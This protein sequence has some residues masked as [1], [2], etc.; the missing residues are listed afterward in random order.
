VARLHSYRESKWPYLLSEGYD[1]TSVETWDYNCIAFVAGVQNQW[2]W[3]DTNG[4]G[5]WP[6]SERKETISCFIKAF[7][8][9]GFEVCDDGLEKGYE[10]IAIFALNGVP[11]H[12]AKQLPNGRWTSKLG[13]WEDIEHNTLKAVEEYV[14][15]KVDTFMRKSITAGA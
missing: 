6:I 9:L 3:P 12:A 10:K 5:Y 14:Y 13:S 15:G 11:T 4:D 2:W 1:V 7:E 8:S